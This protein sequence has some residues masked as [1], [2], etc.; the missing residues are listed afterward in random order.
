M[1][2]KLCKYVIIQ[3]SDHYTRQLKESFST[4]CRSRKFDCR[5]LGTSVVDEVD[6]SFDL[7]PNNFSKDK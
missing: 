4:F 6:H 1:M 7:I 2:D 5:S 3:P